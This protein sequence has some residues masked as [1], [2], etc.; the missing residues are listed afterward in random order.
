M[1]YRGFAAA[2]CSSLVHDVNAMHGL[3]D[4]LGIGDGEIVGAQI[5]ANGE[6]GQGAVRLL[7]GQ[8][9]WNMT[10]VAVPKLAEYRERISLYFDDA[11]LELV[12][13]SPYLNHQ[14]TLLS[15]ATSEGHIVDRRSDQRRLC[16]KPSS[17]SF[18]A[19]TMRS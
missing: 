13:P 9:L 5:F 8:A 1:T 18:S 12:F 3:L 11:L 16:A 7:G 14:P 15:I 6:G 17:K 19:S 10:H 4:Q 2:Y